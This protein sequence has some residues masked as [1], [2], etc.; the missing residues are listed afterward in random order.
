MGSS[1]RF[2]G[3]KYNDDFTSSRVQIEVMRGDHR[4]YCTMS[5]DILT[6]WE[7]CIAAVPTHVPSTFLV[8]RLQ[9]MVMSVLR[10]MGDPS[11]NVSG[12]KLEH[13]DLCKDQIDTMFYPPVPEK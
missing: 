5:Y 11:S 2:C 12:L 4:Q 8:S 13:D 7:E 1:I 10:I 6:S 9:P 3:V